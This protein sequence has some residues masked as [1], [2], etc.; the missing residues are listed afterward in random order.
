MA[1]LARALNLTEEQKSQIQAIHEAERP[2]IEPLVRQLAELRRELR[3]VT[4][5]GQF[6]EAQVRNLA[7]QQAQTFADLIVA[8][9][10]VKSKVY[11]IFTPEQRAK[12]DEIHARMKDRF[13]QRMDR[14]EP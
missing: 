7:N 4:S 13:L 8:K 1:H 14:E 9:E 3:T 10:R 5:Q 2:N 12:L 11:T 6:D